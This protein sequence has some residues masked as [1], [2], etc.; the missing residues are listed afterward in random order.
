LRFKKLDFL[1]AFLSVLAI[2]GFSL[3]TLSDESFSTGYLDRDKDGILDDSDE[4][5]QIAETYNKFED[6][7]GCPDKVP[8]EVKAPY[9][10][11]DSDGDGIEDRKD[12]CVHLPENFN[13]YI[14][15]DGCP[16]IIPNQ[17]YSQ[18][19]SD[20]DTIPD[21][22]DACINEKE[23]FNEF[24]DSDG[25]PDSLFSPTKG[26]ADDPAEPYEQCIG[27]KVPVLRFNSNSVVC[28]TLDTANKWLE[29]GIAEIIEIPVSA[30]PVEPEIPPVEFI[31]P[32]IPPLGLPEYPDQPEIHP[33][34]IAAN[35]FWSPPAVHKVTDGVYSA[36]GFDA[37]NSIMIEGDDGLIIV[38]TLSTYEDAKEVIAEFRKI[39]DK[40]VKAII[41]THGHLDHVH[42]TGAFLEEGK[43]IEIY[44][45]ESHVDFYINEN[46]VLGPITSIR[47]AHAAG[48]FLPDEGPDRKN[49]GVF[50]PMVPGTISYAAPTQTFSD[51]L[52]VEISGVKIKM[53]FVA[54]ESSDQ[55]YVWLPEK[56]VLLIGDNIYAIVPNIYT[57]RGAVYRDPM[58]YVNAL[59]EM[60]PLDAEYLVPSHVKPVSGKETIRDILVST[61]DSAQYIYDQTIR[62][63]NQGYT[64]D[65]LSH[66]IQLPEN[67]DN[68]PWL[69]KTRNEISSH[70]KQI[71]YGNLGWYEGDPAFLTPISMKEKSQ[72]IVNGFG[73]NNAA[74]SSVRN[75]ID[76][77]EYQW[78]AE[79]ATYVIHSNPENEDAK[80]LKAHALR[81]LGQQS[82]SFDIRHW[83]ITEARILEGEITIVPLKTYTTN[84]EQMAELP[85]GKLLEALPTK[86]DPERASGLDMVLSIQYTD[87]GENY[88]LHIRNSI[89]AVTT[90]IP[91]NPDMSLL[92]DSETHKQIVGGHLG[93]LDAIETGKANFVGNQ[94]DLV[95]FIN[96]FDNLTVQPHGIS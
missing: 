8:E 6:K 9:Q 48:A 69:T 79:L 67:L 37:A 30:Q 22:I 33:N 83:S 38:D 75:A 53:V 12:K 94:N 56:E 51:E 90:G 18:R 39:S 2:T 21:S 74:T 82:E 7:D 43:D 5:P 34:L 49:L 35:D 40:P 76:N 19:D 68:H 70:V 80:L 55:I 1:I 93:I 29:Y 15:H 41:Y 61:R 60:I 89:L 32:S 58:N 78:A 73:G 66:M 63:M 52:E 20:S 28:V 85:I 57:I 4:C 91:N 64:A 71:Y 92:I 86:L 72:K 31:P 81:V 25:C 27:D 47:S 84:P 11:P 3:T 17:S 50:P 26:S 13:G 42:G 16:E 36:V 65:E 59:D 62:G 44:A 24:K 45:H 46:S 23:T 14:D 10:F 54:G 77:G 95:N 96:L 87:I 88:I